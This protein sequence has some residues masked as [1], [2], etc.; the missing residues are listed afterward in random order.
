MIVTPQTQR[1]AEPLPQR[2]GLIVLSSHQSHLDSLLLGLA[3]NRLVV[4]EDDCGTQNGI[5]AAGDDKENVGTVLLQ[6]A[7]GLKAGTIIR[8]EHLSKLKGE[9][10][11]VRSP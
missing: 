10:V 5:R 4:T 1:F 3:A 6:D 8:P 9:M 2:G 7:G 11:T